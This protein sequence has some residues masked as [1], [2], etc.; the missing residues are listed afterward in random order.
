MIN[1]VGLLLKLGEEFKLSTQVCVDD[2]VGNWKYLRSQK[3]YFPYL[4]LLPNS[5]LK[6]EFSPS[7]VLYGQN[8]YEISPTDMV[9]ILTILN[10]LLQKGHVNTSPN[11]LF[12]AHVY[13]IDYAKVCYVPFSSQT[14][15]SCLQDIHKGG[16]Y[17]QACTFYVDDGHMAS[18]SL[19]LR[20]MCFYNKSAEIQHDQRNKDELT[21]LVKSLP[22]TFY[23]FECSLKT[24]KEIRRE[25]D[26]CNITLKSYCFKEL[27]RIDVVRT[28]LTKNLAQSLQHW[29]V[30]DRAKALDK[31][32][33][34][35]DGKQYPNTR[36]LL[37][38]LMYLI[39]AIYVGVEEVRQIIE[40]QLGKR[41][42][43]E[44]IK[45]FEKLQL[46]EVNCLAVFKEKFM[47]EVQTLNPL[48]KTY[49]D[50]LT[51]KEIVTD[52]DTCLFA[53]VLLAIVE[54]LISTPLG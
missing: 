4:E 25:L 11:L 17:K 14:L 32:R 31:V 26:A 49:L 48:N 2:I 45:R 50:G 40:K 35:L 12:H 15:W 44:F 51:R 5:K 41:R 38:D 34:C 9:Q 21:E 52:S 13:R 7:K 27:T 42:A 1:T 47:K 43:R 23:R 29:H 18:S 39:S 10:T 33:S 16:H 53:P 6:I 3:S 22:G 30:P 54:L 37:T 20:K 36:T 24:A 28:V 19:K 46:E 8:L